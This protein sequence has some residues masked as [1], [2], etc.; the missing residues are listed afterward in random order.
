MH[1]RRNRK[2]KGRGFKATELETAFN[3]S[4][5]WNIYSWYTNNDYW[6]FNTSPLIFKTLDFNCGER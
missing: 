2:P 4:W 5:Y 3:Y 6:L 1:T